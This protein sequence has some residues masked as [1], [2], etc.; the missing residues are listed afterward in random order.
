[1]DKKL[2]RNL[3]TVAFGVILFV[4]LT[5]IGNIK[6]GFFGAV[7][8]FFPV[9]QGF[10]LAFIINVPMRGIEKRINKLTAKTKKEAEAEI[11][12]NV[13]LNTDRRC[14]LFGYG[15]GLLFG[16]S[17]AFFFSCQPV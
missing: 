3:L 6:D 11:R 8:L 7:N 16:N 14:Y 5:N 15:I 13:Q 12:Q 10:I 2:K 17:C 1:M 9:I 4:A